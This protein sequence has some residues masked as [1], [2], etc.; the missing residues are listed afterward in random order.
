MLMLALNIFSHLHS[1][2]CPLAVRNQGMFSWCNLR[3]SLSAIWLF[4]IVTE[5][6]VSAVAAI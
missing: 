3:F 1:I 4:S 6:P 2:L 5:H